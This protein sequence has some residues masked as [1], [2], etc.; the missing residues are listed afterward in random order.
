MLGVATNELS[1]LDLGLAAGVDSDYV[2]PVTPL[3]P[4]QPPASG[5]ARSADRRGQRRRAARRASRLVIIPGGAHASSIRAASAAGWVNIGQWPDSMS[6]S[7]SAVA[8]A[9][10]GTSPASIHSC[11][12]AGLN[13]GQTSVSRY[14]VAASLVQCTMPRVTPTGT[15]MRAA[16]IAP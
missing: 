5:A 14:A 6:T 9:S 8:V 3:T 4:G 2:L 16:A 11:A 13:S 1:G 10:S 7:S 12:S 15:G